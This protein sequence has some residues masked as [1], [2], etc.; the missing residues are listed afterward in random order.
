MVTLVADNRQGGVVADDLGRYWCT[1]MA[2]KATDTCDVHGGD[3]P[4]VVMRRFGKVEDSFWFGI[5]IHDGGS[6]A[7]AIDFCPWWGVALSR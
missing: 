6:S 7:I 4:D 2:A 3:C 1:T 5:P